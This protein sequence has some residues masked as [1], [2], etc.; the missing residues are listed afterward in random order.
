MRNKFFPSRKNLVLG[1]CFTPEDIIFNTP[2]YKGFKADCDLTGCQD[3]FTS[4]ICVA[5]LCMLKW[6][7]RCVYMPGG[8]LI[9]Q[10]L[11]CVCL[12]P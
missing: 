1:C 5:H 6:H 8:V 9:R 10:A 7:D 11:V 2:I 4:S 12:H 3:S